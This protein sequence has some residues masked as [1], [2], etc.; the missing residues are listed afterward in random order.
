LLLDQYSRYHYLETDETC[1]TEV[2]LRQKLPVEF[3]FTLLQRE[4]KREMRTK[5]IA[6]TYHEHDQD[7]E[8]IEECQKASKGA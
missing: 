4:K 7:Q 8:A 6:C 5:G 2:L 3:V 1:G